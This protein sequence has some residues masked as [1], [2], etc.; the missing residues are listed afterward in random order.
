MSDALYEAMG[1]E[2]T[3]TRLV[4][5][6]YEGVRAD[7]VLA[8]MYPQEDW[9]GAE[10]RLRLFLM[11]YWG[12]PTTYSERRGHPMLRRRHVRFEIDADARDRWLRHMRGAVEDVSLAPE[13]EQVLWDYLLR[14]AHAMVNTEREPTVQTDGR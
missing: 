11:Q 1:G 2:E 10:E 7:P 8:P 3:F 5:R 4:R 14:A 12:G 9:E 13:V 6:F